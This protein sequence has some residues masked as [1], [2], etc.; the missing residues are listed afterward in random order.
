MATE[1]AEHVTVVENLRNQVETLS[2]EN[3]SLRRSVLLYKCTARVLSKRPYKNLE[4]VQEV[5]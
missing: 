1:V 2:R 5:K 4:P 3:Q